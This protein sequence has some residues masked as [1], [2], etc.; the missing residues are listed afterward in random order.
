MIDNAIK[1][2]QQIMIET[3][4]LPIET[5]I[6]GLVLSLRRSLKADDMSILAAVMVRRLAHLKD[7]Q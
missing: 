1:I 7:S 2:L 6:A 4:N 5:Q 3:P